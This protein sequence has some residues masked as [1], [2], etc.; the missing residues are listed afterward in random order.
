MTIYCHIHIFLSNSQL[1]NQIAKNTAD[2]FLLVVI[3]P[4]THAII[5]KGK[6][7]N[8]EQL[9][10]VSHSL[11]VNAL[12]CRWEILSLSL[13]TDEKKLYDKFIRNLS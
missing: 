8:K 10:G 6:G 4:C 13:P 7:E 12:R 9:I 3:I 11:V 1:W 2:V 5:C